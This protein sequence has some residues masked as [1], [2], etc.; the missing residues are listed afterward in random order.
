[1]KTT[2]SNAKSQWCRGITLIECLVCI[3]AVAVVLGLSTAAFYQ[4]MDN[5]IGLQRNADDIVRTLNAG[6]RWRA[7]V[8]SATMPPQLEQTDQAWLLTIRDSTSEI[9]YQFL[10]NALVRRGSPQETWTIVLE[11]VKS[12]QVIPEQRQHVT[13]WRLELELEQ[14]RKGTRL[15]PLFSFLAV[16]TGLQNK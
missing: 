4:C 8:R 12:C 11:R 7:D 2:S 9:R 10:T 15:H 5:S 1:M 16:P 3:G 13:V 6:E 14:Y